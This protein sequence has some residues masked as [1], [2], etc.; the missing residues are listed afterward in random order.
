VGKLAPRKVFATKIFFFL[1]LSRSDDAAADSFEIGVKSA[2][3]QHWEILAGVPLAPPFFG[4]P[5]RTPKKFRWHCV[6]IPCILS[7]QFRN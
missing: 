5:E 6:Q 3:E 4:R 7:V 1:K 2:A